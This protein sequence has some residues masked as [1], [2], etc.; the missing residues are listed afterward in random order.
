MRRKKIGEK[1]GEERE[2]GENA[3]VQRGGTL[4]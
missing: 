4:K 2:V 1:E 3:E